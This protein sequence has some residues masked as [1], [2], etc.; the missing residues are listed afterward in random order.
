[1]VARNARQEAI[2]AIAATQPVK[3]AIDP[4]KTS[5]SEL[6]GENVFNMALMRKVLPKN[7]FAS[8]VKT[9][10]KGEK[11]D[12]TNADAIAS[13]M[14]EWAVAK[15]ATHYTHQFQPMTGITAE[16]HDSF[17]NYTSDG[18]AINEFPG[19]LLIQGEPDASSFPSGGLRATF[20]ARGYTAWDPTSPAFI[21]EAINGKTLVIP[22]A[23]CGWKGEALDE[24]T[25]LLRATDALSKQAVRLL[26]ILGKEVSR[27]YSTMGPEQEYFLI[28]RNF[29]LQRPD[30]IAAG[31]TLFGAK[32]PKGQEMEDHYFG[33]I[34]PRILAFMNDVETECY[35]LGIPLKTR[36][37]EVAPAQ[38][39]VAPIFEAANVAADHNMVV[40]EIFRQVA[41][42]H[43]LQALFHEKPFAGVNGS[44]KHNNW[45]MATDKG[46]N[47]LEPGHT[48]EENAQFIV[49]LAVVVR[50]VNK[51]SKLLR[52]GIAQ[53][54]N[55]HRLGA[56][57]APP[58]IISVY[59]GEKLQDVVDGIVKGAKGKSRVGGTLDIG[60]TMLPTL[61][62]D[63]SDRNRTSPFAFTG[64]KF[65]F[66]A[67]GS[68]QA[69][70]RPNSYLNVAVA[71]SIDHVATE[72]EKKM[73]GG[74]DLHSAIN[75]VVKEVLADNL[76]VVWNG[77]NYTKE[78]HTEAAKRGLPNL[79]NT[80]DAVQSLHDKE[81]VK[82]LSTYGVLSEEEV[83]SRHT[84]MLENYIK[85]INIEA[86]TASNIARQQLLPASLKYQMQLA[87]TVTATK[88]ASK[89]AS[90]AAAEKGLKDV[91]ELTASL[92]EAIEAL[93]KTRAEADSHGG[94]HLKHAMHY[95][96]EVVPAMLKVRES[97]DALELLVD[98]QLWP[99]PKYRE[100]LFV[101]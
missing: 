96:D 43:G 13:A 60:A 87:E 27:V 91:S 93:D 58:A 33:S 11:L 99:L 65:E 35:K 78:W 61:P 86:L 77:D 34:R 12:S 81:I 21:L 94:D 56:N 62:R 95:R 3:S 15:G 44:G 92:A 66:R 32:P 71:E 47:L 57:E 31:R 37:N 24:K 84:I 52:V 28:D 46:E 19:K 14:K 26:K 45:S 25:P 88:A 9:I 97:A 53:S 1:M 79:K 30:L 101:Y 51:W 41:N 22:T 70:A 4:T 67:V 82:L 10:E 73:K 39:E 74:K 90:S 6:Y 5:I 42:K 68:S 49:F 50:A 64:N 38:F 20:E 8:L 98:D 83:S 29:Y 85:T 100:M 16:K 59:L 75:I 76:K 69:I 63:A 17:I 72:L 18:T 7:V 54:G 55:D 48:P 2:K 80:V 36:H 23:F 40:M 89:G